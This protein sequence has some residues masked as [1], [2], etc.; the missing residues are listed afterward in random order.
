[1]LETMCCCRRA[2]IMETSGLGYAGAFLFG[3]RATCVLCVSL[4][5]WTSPALVW[6]FVPWYS[7]ACPMILS[8]SQSFSM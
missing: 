6:V 4:V 5:A 7:G 8:L 3:H 2:H 1:M